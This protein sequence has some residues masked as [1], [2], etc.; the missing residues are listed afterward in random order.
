MTG[1]HIEVDCRLCHFEDS[2][3]SGRFKQIFT[4]LNPE[5][6]QCHK[7]VHG[8]QFEINSVTDCKRCH[9]TEQWFP[10]NFNHNTT[11]FPLDGKHAELEC[12]ACHIPSLDA[13]GNEVINYKIEK[14]ECIDCHS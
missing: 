3:I 7:N 13:S 2:E 12:A 8:D 9:D 11:D 6:I 4:D 10:N 1:A 5:C 14:H